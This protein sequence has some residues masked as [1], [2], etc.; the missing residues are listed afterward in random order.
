VRKPR[1]SLFTHRGICN[2][3]G[4]RVQG[5][6]P[7]NVS[8]S[9]LGTDDAGA[10]WTPALVRIGVDSVD[11]GS[12][13]EHGDWFEAANGHLFRRIGDP[14]NFPSPLVPVPLRIHVLSDPLRDQVHTNG[15]FSFSEPCGVSLPPEKESSCCCGH[16]SLY[17]SDQAA[18]GVAGMA[19]IVAQ[20]R[21]ENP[22]YK[23]SRHS[24][25]YRLC[26]VQ[27]SG[28]V[29]RLLAPDE[30]PLSALYGGRRVRWFACYLRK[31]RY[32]LGSIYPATSWLHLVRL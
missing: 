30:R 4:S 24:G 5:R 28:R 29:S 21:M 7:E 6:N 1:K 27:I 22:R 20:P 19:C 10:T 11:R 17:H 25:P 2:A 12:D 9:S 31:A 18:P 16:L 13:C 14:R 15:A 23:R 8:L 32:I 3:D 26:A